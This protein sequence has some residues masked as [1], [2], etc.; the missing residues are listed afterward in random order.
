MYNENDKKVGGAVIKKI[1]VNPMPSF[2]FKFERL[3]VYF[4]TLLNSDEAKKN[5]PQLKLLILNSGNSAVAL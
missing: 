4:L 2:F 5:P 1:L 3:F